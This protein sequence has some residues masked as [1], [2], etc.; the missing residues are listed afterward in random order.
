MYF[1]SDFG[2]KF[3]YISK[4]ILEPLLLILKTRFYWLG[5]FDVDTM[6]NAIFSMN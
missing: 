1:S 2:A 4:V 5:S 3:K 6:L